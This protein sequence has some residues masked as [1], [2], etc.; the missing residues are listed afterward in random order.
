MEHIHLCSIY[1]YFSPTM[2][3]L[4]SWSR[5]SVAHKAKSIYY[6]APYRTKFASPWIKKWDCTKLTFENFKEFYNEIS[7]FTALLVNTLPYVLFS[8][9]Y[10]MFALQHSWKCHHSWGKMCPLLWTTKDCWFLSLLIE[11][12]RYLQFQIVRT[13]IKAF[14][15]IYIILYCNYWYFN[16]KFWLGS[17]SWS[18]RVTLD[19]FNIWNMSI[20]YYFANIFKAV[21]FS[22]NKL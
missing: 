3:E 21:G 2:A 18:D 17:F 5:G 9:I 10:S 6:P 4:S 8:F 11:I 7:V 20:W 15:Y 1:S 16:T 14:L 22:F 19:F 12:V 13:G